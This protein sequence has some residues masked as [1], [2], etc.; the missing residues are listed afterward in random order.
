MGRR[1][2]RGAVSRRQFLALAGAGANQ[3]LYTV[4]LSD[5]TLAEATD[6]RGQHPSHW[7][8]V[9]T[10]T[11]V[12]VAQTKFITFEN[13]AV[14]VLTITNTDTAPTTRTLTVASP[15]ASTPS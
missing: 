9:H 12:S 3:D 11:G 1:I 2:R 13:V 4:T 6:R 14:T 15:I 7:T 5:A 8:S 10:A